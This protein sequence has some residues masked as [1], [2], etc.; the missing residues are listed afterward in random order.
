MIEKRD[1]EYLGRQLSLGEV[2]LFTG[3]GFSAGCTSE[4]GTALPTG[5]GM[6]ELLWPHAFPGEPFNNDEAL[7]DIFEVALR[8][9]RNGLKS[10]LTA[11]LTIE[12]TSIPAYYRTYMQ[13]PWHRVYTLN[14]D[15]FWT[16][17]PQIDPLA[18]ALTPVSALTSE[19]LPPDTTATVVHLNGVL[20]D[21]PH[22][23]FSQ[24]QY[25][26]R[27]NTND[28]WYAQLIA[29]LF[30]H[31]IVF[32]G[33]ELNEP[34][35]WEHLAARRLRSY[36]GGER[37]PR[38]FLVTPSI[39]PA[40]RQLLKELNI[41]HL[42]GYAEDFVNDVLVGLKDEL[43]AG[44]ELLRRR[45]AASTSV[46][47]IEDVGILRH[48]APPPRYEAADFLLG[49][50]PTWRDFDEGYAVARDFDHDLAAAVSSTPRGVIIV[51][52]TAG[53]G[54]STAL[55]RAALAVH[56]EGHRTLWFDSKEETELRL[57]QLRKRISDVDARYLFI[58]DVDVFGPVAAQ[59]LKDVVA[60]NDLLLVAG[61]RANRVRAVGLEPGEMI[62]AIEMTVP[63]L[64]D[65]DIALLIDALDDANRLGFL[66]G[67]SRQ[68]QVAVF[69]K[70]FDRQLLVAMLEAT[71]G[72]RFEQLIRD[73]CGELQGVQ[74]E[75]YGMVC[76]ATSHRAGLRREELLLGVGGDTA[77]A[78][79]E[80]HRMLD[81]RLLTI[82]GRGLI[83]ARHRVVAERAIEQVKRSGQLQQII[84]GLVFAVATKVG[85]EHG[86]G[87]RENRLL[88]RLIN[89]DFLIEQLGDPQSIR[90]VY[91][92]IEDILG[93]DFHY[94]LQ[95]GSFEVERGSVTQAENFLAQ[96]KALAPDNLFVRTEWAY[97]LMVTAAGE[98]EAGLPLHH[99]HADEGMVELFD[100]IE[101]RGR[102]TP[103]PFHVLAR[104]GLAWL[105]HAQLSPTERA[106]YLG[107]ILSYLRDGVKLHPQ[108][109]E[110]R[111]IERTIERAYLGVAVDS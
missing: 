60:E 18:R 11:A 43:S 53:T 109:R 77:E 56:S 12:S 59:F 10:T 111:T 34:P 107:R 2:V 16:I 81:R 15:N 49:R 9:D 38:S 28:K 13:A 61:I 103:Y 46:S 87:S 69:R 74:Y 50:Q 86:R 96:A 31:C 55:M 35:L 67:K 70:S 24:R 71:S 3:A 57:W 73:E 25:G 26:E 84:E 110:L 54:K 5:R 47:I 76:F 29:D 98:A 39:T 48:A 33:T 72:E 41:V 105:E 82:D 20:T 51:T 91:A 108:S 90:P 80:L 79:S 42:P 106:D 64:A 95:R 30:G 17:A 88:A 78:L 62:D 97:M 99:D 83:N 7:G 19:T 52:G 45:R 8:Q 6:R 89:H 23:S 65:D 94:W 75:L 58:D 27:A 44:R 1:R 36:R 102:E 100:V 37:R 63:G 14:F 92:L 85:P 32:V 68:D 22:V 101:T 40:R 66:K 4:A 93:W 21:F 104:Q